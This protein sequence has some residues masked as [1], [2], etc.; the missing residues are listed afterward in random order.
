[1]GCAVLHATGSNDWSLAN[2][3]N[4]IQQLTQHPATTDPTGNILAGNERTSVS[5]YGQF[6]Y[7]DMELRLERYYGETGD[8]V[9]RWDTHR[10]E[11]E[12]KQP[13]SW[14]AKAK[15][16]SHDA[17]IKVADFSDIQA[18]VNAL[19]LAILRLLEV[20]TATL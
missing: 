4:E 6:F 14:Y 5:V 15:P 1:M 18:L 8:T 7:N 16:L 2:L 19:T 20:T 10:K 3:I 9:F 11:L 13:N 12:R 17:Q